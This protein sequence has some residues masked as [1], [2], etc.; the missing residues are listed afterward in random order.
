MIACDEVVRDA[1][2]NEPVELKCTFYPET[3]AGVTPEGETR[4]KG[5]IQ[6]VEATSGAQCQ[7]MQYDR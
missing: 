1:T 7:V 5:I 3:R 2:T 4:V 6:W